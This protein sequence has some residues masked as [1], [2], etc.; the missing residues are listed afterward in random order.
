MSSSVLPTGL[1]E[2][3]GTDIA[4]QTPGGAWQPTPLG[5]DLVTAMGPL[6]DWSRVWAERRA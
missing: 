4:E 5:A 2:L 3:R 1:T 6:L